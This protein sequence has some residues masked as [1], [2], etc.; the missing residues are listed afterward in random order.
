M[1]IYLYIHIHIYICKYIC[2]CIYTYTYIYIYIYICV[3]IRISYICIYTLALAARSD[4]EVLRVKIDS[5]PPA[6]EDRPL[7]V[8]VETDIVVPCWVYSKKVLGY[9]VQKFVDFIEISR[10]LSALRHCLQKVATITIGSSFLGEASEV[11]TTP[12][13]P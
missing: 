5:V 2:I 9:H 4:F 6:V 3:Y 12:L 10:F 7:I 8:K 11:V 1:Y 13:T